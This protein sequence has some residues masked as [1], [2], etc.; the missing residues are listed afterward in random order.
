[1]AP[2]A[3]P[4]L[5]WFGHLEWVG[6]TKRARPGLK[7]EYKATAAMLTEKHPGEVGGPVNDEPHRDEMRPTGQAVEWVRR[8]Y[9]EKLVFSNN[10]ARRAGHVRNY[11]KRMKPDVMMFDRYPFSPKH[12]GGG[13]PTGGSSASRRPAGRPSALGAGI[14]Y[15]AFVQSFD[16]SG[17]RHFSES[18][19]RVQIFLDLTCG[20]TGQESK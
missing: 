15:W 9:A 12:E 20:F 11:L 4:G 13:I 6:R 5:T 1:M 19:L 7:R 16:R 18:D 2:P 10:F 8:K 17:K 3:A 14:P